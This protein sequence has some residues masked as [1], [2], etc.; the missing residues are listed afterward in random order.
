[1][2]WKRF[3]IISGSFSLIVGS[4]GILYA[5]FWPDNSYIEAPKFFLNNV[6]HQRAYAPFYYYVGDDANGYWPETEDNTE[7][8]DKNIMEWKSYTHNKISVGDLEL[9][10]Y[11]MPLADLEKIAKAMDSGRPMPNCNDVFAKWLFKHKDFT[12]VNYL[13]YAKR[14]ETM[15]IVDAYDWQVKPK[16]TAG[17]VSFINEG[18]KRALNMRDPFFKWRYTYQTLKLEF[19]NHLYENTLRIYDSLIGKQSFK[20]EMYARCLGIKAGALLHTNNNAEAAYIYSRVFDMNDVLKPNMHTSYLWCGAEAIKDGY[21]YCRNKHEMAI[22]HIMS[23]LQEGNGADMDF[24]KNDMFMAYKLD[25]KVKGLDI[26]MTRQINKLEYK[27]YDEYLNNFRGRRQENDLGTY[28]M[29]EWKKWKEKEKVALRYISLL[30]SFSKKLVVENKTGKNA[31][32]LLSSAYLNLMQGNTNVCE[33]QLSAAEKY[34]LHP[35]EQDVDKI[36]H[37]VCIIEHAPKIDSSIEMQLLPYLTWIEN[38]TISG[39]KGYSRFCNVYRGILLDVLSN[40]Y[41]NQHDTLKYV[42]C[43]ARSQ[44]RMSDLHNVEENSN[45]IPISL[46]FDDATGEMV[47]LLSEEKLEALIKLTNEKQTNPYLHWLS[48]EPFYTTDMLYEMEAMH[49][50]NCTNFSKAHDYLAKLNK[51]YLDSRTF[52][53]PF[54]SFVKDYYEVTPP[55]GRQNI[56][57]LTFVNEMLRLERVMKEKPSNAKAYYR[58]A[59]GLYNTSFYGYAHHARIFNRHYVDDAAYFK[60]AARAKLKD[61]DRELYEVTVPEKYFMLA[62]SHAKDQNFKARCL[63]MAAKCWQKNCYYKEGSAEDDY[64]KRSIKSP[65]FKILYDHYRKTDYYQEAYNTCSYLKDYAKSYNSK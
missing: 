54:L 52:T 1:M 62:F 19:Y 41:F 23:A 59:L 58:Y 3:L 37:T 57:K 35:K 36:I 53:Y 5:C 13:I 60:S 46:D 32:W 11:K 38:R 45:S 20:G 10:I 56:N 34:K 4:I 6:T 15:Q 18:K 40:S 42:L 12:A 63:F 43:M 61:C 44:K 14:A 22:M 48:S 2:S 50:I 28:E 39:K 26:L 31:F 55:P 65:Y 27:Y 30:D 33:E 49:F 16:D 24:G 64:V 51:P 17:L 9:L 47:K 25:P 21:K 8:P 29:N 7:L